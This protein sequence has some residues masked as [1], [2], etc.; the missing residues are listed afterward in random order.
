M[1]P[2]AQA[3]SV[4][5]NSIELIRSAGEIAYRFA[6]GDE[7]TP[8]NPFRGPDELKS[9]LGLGLDDI[10]SPIDAVMQSLEEIVNATPRS[11]SKRFYNQLFGGRDPIATAADMLAPVINT[12]LYTFKASGPMAIIEQTVI[13]HMAQILGFPSDTHEGVFTPGGSI[14]N[15]VAMLI[16]RNQAAPESRNNGVTGTR[17]TSYIS[18]DAHYSVTKNAGIIGIGRANVRKIKTDEHGMVCVDDLREKIEQDIADGCTPCV[19]VA[20][21][22]TTV[23][24]AFDP[25]EAMGEI[26]REHK[27][28]FH[29]DASY[30]GTIA[31]S[32]THKHLMKG[33]GHADSVAWN[34][35]KVMGIPLSAAA[36]ITRESGFMRQSLDETAEYLFQA[37]DDQYNPGTRSIQCGRRNDALKVW[38]AWKH[39]GDSGYQ[40]RIN[41]LMDLANHVA[42]RVR[43]HDE[44]TLSCEPAYINVCFEV[45]GKSS[46]AIC[47]LL[48]E[49]NE[50][51]VGHAV[52]DGRRIIR[53]PFV[54]GDLSKDDVDQMLGFIINAAQQLPAGDNTVER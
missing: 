1:Q 45:T 31:L 34:P 50:L 40:Q 18:E 44:L 29:V 33:V 49:R 27:V 5:P 37:D 17:L 2:S 14:S 25:I 26:A 43:A 42:E 23:R 39:H 41:H 20:T 48:R 53:V 15:L 10:G 47:D 6:Q 35:H 54:N 32:S 13:E 28:W 4:L 22:G 8:V 51:I 21:A 19:V 11:T 12:S 16:A 3:T 7:D 52:V 30:G 38:A 9:L 46:Q 36:F 24:G